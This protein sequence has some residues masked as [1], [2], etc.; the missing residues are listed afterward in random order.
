MISYYHDFTRHSRKII[1]KPI[2]HIIMIYAR[3]TC[4]FTPNTAPHPSA[5]LCKHI[6][7]IS[8]RTYHTMTKP[9]YILIR[10]SSNESGYAAHPFPTETAAY[11]A[12]NCMIKSHTAAISHPPCVE[13]VSSYKTQLI[14]NAI[15]AESDMTVKI[16]YSVYEVK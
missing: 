15:I 6:S 10:E 9:T 2:N 12:M 3:L 1:S 8:E 7:Y 11:T 5:C 4:V 14:F 16:T 13:Q